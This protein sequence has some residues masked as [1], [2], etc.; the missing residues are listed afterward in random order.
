MTRRCFA[1]GILAIAAPAAVAVAAAAGK[2]AATSL[3][4]TINNK[5]Q[6]ANAAGT[7]GYDLGKISCPTPLG[8]GLEYDK[9]SITA[10]GTTATITG[11]FKLYF[12]Q[13]T[14]H[15]TF[16]LKS[17]A[18][19]G[20][21]TMSSGKLRITGGTGAFKRVGGTGTVS[22]TSTTPSNGQTTSHYKAHLT[23]TGI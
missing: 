1:V 3:R 10:T 20:G 2:P 19:S 5:T 7:K 21:T 22:G 15:G 8:A 12:N 11:P 18:G 13:G 23:L 14:L 9:F 6:S 16:K 17:T 4:C